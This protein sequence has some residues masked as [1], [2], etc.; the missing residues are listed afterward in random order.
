MSPAPPP[1]TPAPAT[2]APATPAPDRAGAAVSLALVSHTNVGKTT[3][4]R[5]LLGRD[6]GEVR[7]APHVTEFADEHVLVETADGV[8]LTLWDT[9]GFGDT[10]R[11]VRRLRQA[12]QPIGWFLSQVWDRFTDRAF[13]SSQQALK[14]V[15]EHADVVLY[16][17]NASESPAAAGYV[18]P[19]MDLLEWVGCPVVVLLNQLGP[20]RPAAEE[21]ADV[22]RWRRHLA[23]HAF[24]RAVLPLDAFARCW[25]QEAAWL[26]AVERALG[27]GPERERM[28][29]LRAEWTRR[30]EAQFDA[31]MDALAASLARSALARQTL[32]DAGRLRETVRRLR[33]ALGG[34]GRT[35]DDPAAL[36]QQALAARHDEEVRRSTAELVGLHGLSGRAE[37]EILARVAAHY[38]T[39]TPVDEGRAAV[40]GGLLTGALAGLKAD[41]VSGGLTLGGG[42]LAGG[43]LGA[44]G[45][46]GA[47]RAANLVRGVGSGWVGWSDEA[48]QAMT[49]AALLRYLAV[50]H[51]GRGRGDWSAGE[52]PPHWRSVVAAALA[53]RREALAA[54]WDAA[55]DAAADAPPATGPDAGAAALADALRPLLAGA[56]RE[57]LGRLYPDAYH[58][59]A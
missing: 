6:V 35:A 27:D 31:A 40:L 5:T 55:R 51:F 37:G 28:A 46:A 34:A 13:W 17:V 23:P 54:A 22:D 38:E 20:P 7:D 10:V 3:L 9:P 45:A 18:A 53:P 15:R 39:R 8:R 11:L 44:I 29:A 32:T 56:A 58:P 26:A 42:L 50:A 57:A 59:A 24:V 25:V 16:L 48:L 52:S 19:E 2:P 4:A 14:A 43:L 21:Q 41:L 47:A 49:D 36:A 12:G 30:R 1:T 33:G